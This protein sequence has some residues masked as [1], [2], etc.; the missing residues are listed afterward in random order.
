MKGFL[1]AL[2]CPSTHA[3]YLMSAYIT[4]VKKGDKS[5]LLF[6]LGGGKSLC[7][8]LP[9]LVN[10]GVSI[11]ISPLKALIQDQVTRLNSMEVCIFIS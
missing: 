3:H 9:A 1:F 8:Q 6:H 11:I 7:Y 5:C 10:G 2:P 4:I